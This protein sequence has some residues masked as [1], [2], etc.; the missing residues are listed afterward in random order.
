M[1]ARIKKSGNYQYV[2]VVH[3]QRID[4][5]V[6]QRVVATLGRLDVLKETGQLDGLVESL[7][8]FSD[9]VT[10]L[11]ALKSNQ[12]TPSRTVHLGPPLVFEKLWKQLGMPEILRRLLEGRRFE[13]PL[14]RVVFI[15]VLHRLFVSGSDR[16]AERWCR[17]YALGDLGDLDLQHFY[18]TMGWLGEPLPPDGQPDEGRLGPRLRKDLIEEALFGRR[19]DLFT[20][21]R[22]VFIDTT[23][24]YFEGQGGETIGK[25]GYSKDHRPDLKQMIV[26]V[27]MDDEGRPVCCELLPGNTADISTLVPIVDRLRERFQIRDVCVVAD[28][29]MISEK[30]IAELVERGIRYILGARLRNVKEIRET[31][32]SRPGRYR[33]VQGPR[34][35]SKSPSPLKVKQVFVE[36]RRYIVCHNDEQA[37]K[38]QADREAILEKLRERLKQGGTSLVGN[39]G[40]RKYLTSAKGGAFQVDEAK[41]NQDARFDGKWVLRTDTDL[42]AEEVALR[43]KDLLLVED[44]FRTAKSILETRPIFHKCD[45]TIRG[46]VFCSFL[47]L[48]LLKELQH[49]LASHGW[50]V[51][52]QHLRD[53]LDELQELTLPLGDKTFAI[54]TPPVG[55]AVR[56]IQAVGVVLGPSVRRIG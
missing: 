23:S 39:K 48:V 54:R 22:L 26:V 31:V 37:R 30:T 21:L 46:H 8:R 12:I 56:A 10:I 51:E 40:Y 18:R 6:R 9:H 32:L 45:D 33:V 43:Y 3:N 29:G 14:E 25:R 15:T 36:D 1:F 53:D 42:P 28:R 34:E 50:Q 27:V 49:Q 16:A 11:N 2:Q 47:A 35:N 13:F 4:G 44:A 20:G 5:R 38:D 52:W 41:V 19:R 24:I 55:E 7:A 17:K